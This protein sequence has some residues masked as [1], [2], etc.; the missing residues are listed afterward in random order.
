MGSSTEQSSLSFV[1]RYNVILKSHYFL[2]FSAFGVIFP[3]LNII[4]RSRGLSNTEISL[5][6]LIM[7]FLVFFSSPLMG[8]IAD[9]TRRFRLTFN[10]LLSIV[11]VSFTILFL[12]P[13]IQTQKI[14]ADLNNM[15][16][17]TYGLTFCTSQESVSK[18]SARSECGCSYQS[19][20]AVADLT[21]NFTMTNDFQNSFTNGPKSKCGTEYRVQIAPDTL[22]K[23]PGWLKF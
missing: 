9:K 23:K 6:N 3:I 10:I 11:I 5:S 22:S 17:S 12:L 20:C 14:Q 19:Y 18:C 2:F 13:S 16:E 1:R 4:L 8:F 15:G 7:P 21:V